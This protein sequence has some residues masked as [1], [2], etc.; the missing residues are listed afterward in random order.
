[1]RAADPLGGRIAYR[2]TGKIKW[3][4]N[5]DVLDGVDRLGLPSESDSR[6]LLD[7]FLSYLNITQHFLD[8]R[9]FIDTMALLFQSEAT[10]QAQMG[11]IW[12]VQYLLVMAVGKL[13][14]K[15]TRSYNPFPGVAYFT[16][17]MR[18][19]PPL[20]QLGKFGVI[21]VEILCLVTMY[22]QWCDCKHDAYVH[23]SFQAS[24]RTLD[25][26]SPPLPDWDRS[27]IGHCLGTCSAVR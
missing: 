5:L 18:L 12:F 21:S 6:R 14:D 24:P 15:D 7:L 10:R 2:E 8:P 17:A 9:A 4:P 23:V 11:K 27:K 19:L 13:L 20:H 3:C 25:F 1:V 22:L 26:D 16:E